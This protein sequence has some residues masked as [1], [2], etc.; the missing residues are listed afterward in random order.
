MSKVFVLMLAWSL[1]GCDASQSQQAPHA[2]RDEAVQSS[3][4]SANADGAKHKPAAAATEAVQY[5]GDAPGDATQTLPTAIARALGTDELVLTCA[6]G[7]RDGIS[8]FAADWVAV[9]RLDLNGDGRADWIVHGRNPCLRQA[10][11]AYW[12]L[13]ENTVDTPRL[14][15]RAE[16]ARSLEVLATSTR[17]YRDLRMQIA[18]G[19]SA[20]VADNKYDGQGY[21]PAPP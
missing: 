11:A 5:D 12:W 7:T 19:R 2:T 21:S 10:D 18:G 16:P 9:D 8:Q 20:L 3:P 15:L 1:A 17:G 13:Y 4:G 14:L 6:D